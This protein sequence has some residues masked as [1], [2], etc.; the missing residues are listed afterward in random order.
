MEEPYEKE[1]YNIFKSFDSDENDELDHKGVNAL[2]ETLQLDFSQ[3][4]QLWSFLDQNSNVSFE[5]FRD[6]LVYLANNGSKDETY[7]RDIS[8][9]REISPKYVFGEKKYGRRTKPREDSFILNQSDII[10][11]L[12]NS[13]PLSPRKLEYIHINSELKSDEETQNKDILSQ[14]D[15]KHDLLKERLIMDKH[16]LSLACEHMGITSSGLISKTQL[17]DVIQHFDCNEKLFEKINDKYSNDRIPIKEVLE[18]ISS[19]DYRSVSPNSET[20]T[21]GVSST[22]YY[23]REDNLPNTMMVSINTIIELWESCGIPESVNLLQELG[24]DTSLDSVYIPDLVTTVSNQLHKVRNNFVDSSLTE[25]DSINTPFVLLKAISSLNEYQVKWLKMIIEQM[26]CERDKLKYDVDTANN[27][28]VMLAQEVDENHMRLEK[29]SANKIAALE[30]K[31]HEERKTLI[32]QWGSEKDQ[33][34]NQNILLNDKLQQVQ[35]YENE[36]QSELLN[37]KKQL[38]L[39]E[40]ENSALNEQLAELKQKN[41]SLEVQVQEIPQLKLKEL[42]LESNNEQ[43]IDLV[44]K[45][46]GLKNENKCLRDQNDELVIELEATKMIENVGNDRSFDSNVRNFLAEKNSPN[47]FG[48]VKEFTTDFSIEEGGSDCTNTFETYTIESDFD[49]WNKV[50]N[51]QKSYHK[52]PQTSLMLVNNIKT[53]LSSQSQ[54][55]SCHLDELIDY[56]EHMKQ[57]QKSDHSQLV[58]QKESPESMHESPDSLMTSSPLNKYPTRRSLNKQ[59]ENSTETEFMDST[60]IEVTNGSV[61]KL[62]QMYNQ[63]KSE[64]QEL[65]DK[66]E[67]I[68]KYWESRYNQLCEVADKALDEAKRLKDEGTELERGIDALRNE[69]FECEEYWSLKLEEERKLNELEK[70]VSEEK[71]NNLEVKIKE[72]SDMLEETTDNKLPSIDENAELEEQ[73]NCIQQE[74]S[75]YCVQIEKEMEK[76]KIENERFKSQIVTPAEKVDREVANCQFKEECEKCLENLKKNGELK[77]KQFDL[78]KNREKLG[79]ECRS[80]LQRRS[81]LKN[82]ILQLQEYLNVLSNTHKEFFMQKEINQANQV[83]IDARRCKELEQRLHDEQARHQKLTNAIWNEHQSKIDMVHKLLRSSQDKLEEQ[84]KM[85]NEQN[86]QLMSADMIVKE[87]FIENAKLMSMIHSLQT[88]IDRSSNYNSM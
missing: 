44:Q 39:L 26:N 73:I 30:H 18:L 35:N 9:V 86:K 14:C 17:F 28:A 80:L 45:I 55:E 46:D 83:S 72:Y 31:H 25:Y 75:S 40:S 62:K 88:Q 61:E 20:S 8:P 70:K 42:E 57:R 6:A 10:Q 21:S 87:L 19:L 67:K 13:I 49:T 2:C 16:N 84:I 53:T 33:L 41:V 24:I 85:R 56:L 36:L 23:H 12:N 78:K 34:L 29:S 66:C 3:R 43:I 1:L 54:I 15:D 63:S 32:D 77:N 50:E 60:L 68:E 51:S 38:S 81:A 69:Y 52:S 65:R 71:L 64:N 82:E 11:D 7:S 79:M 48:K 76:L 58:E 74:F 47:C 37:N 4:K 27:R 22:S 59:F 5:Q